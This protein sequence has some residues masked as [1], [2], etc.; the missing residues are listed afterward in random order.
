MPHKSMQVG[1]NAT[2]PYF[3]PR[4]APRGC[5]VTK[6]AKKRATAVLM[7]LFSSPTSSVKFADSAFPIYRGLSSAYGSDGAGGFDQRWLCPGH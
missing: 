6:K 5:R 3:L 7:S 1:T 2:M 4:T